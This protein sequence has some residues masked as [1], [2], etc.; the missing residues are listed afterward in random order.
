M[1]APASG[2]GRPR[3]RT[4]DD[5]VLAAARELLAAVGYEA[6]S[7]SAVAEAA[8]TTRQALYRRWSSK[9]DLATAAVAAMSEADARPETDDPFAD[10]QRELDAFRQG[11][12]RR[13][14]ISLVGAML[15]DAADPELRAKFRERL[16]HPRRTR[17]R[18]ILDR[19][20][21]AGLLDADADL[22]VAVAA[23]TGILYAQALAGTRPP[24]AWATRVARHVWRSCGGVPPTTPS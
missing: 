17:L 12:S 5:A 14:G 23:C 20:V 13:N 6:L 1:G 8:G 10:L 2:P 22:D 16:V 9:A 18:A 4:I 3:D 15:Q 19:G 24:K 21:A 7:M 11:V